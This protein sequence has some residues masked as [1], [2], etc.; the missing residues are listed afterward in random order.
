MNL[1]LEHDRRFLTWLKEVQSSIITTSYKTNYIFCI[2]LAELTELNQEVLKPPREQLSLWQTQSARCMGVGRTPP[3]KE[4][5]F[6]SI[7]VGNLNMLTKYSYF[8]DRIDEG[9]DPEKNILFRRKPF[10][11]L[12]VPRKIHVTSDIDIH[13]IAISNGTPHFV[14]AVFSCVC[15]PSETDSFKVYWKP[16]WIS[17]IAAE[18]RTHLNGLCTVPGPDGSGP[19]PKYVTAVARTDT[20]GGWRDHKR[21]GGVIFDIVNNLLVSENLSMPHSPRW[22]NCRLWVLNS[23]KGQFGYIDFDKPINDNFVPLCFI[24][25]FLRG[26]DFI[27]GYAVIGSSEDRH[28]KTFQGLELGEILEEKKIKA[29]CAIHIVDLKT[30]DIVHEI[31]FGTQELYDVTILPHVVRPIID[32]LQNSSI[33]Q[34]LSVE[35]M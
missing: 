35:L 6:D 32:D 25:G 8:G 5:S 2:G 27:K 17:K 29:K 4:N 9:K 24:P 19:I 33:S 18:D 15:V 34:R 3:S 20:R 14:S 31:S 23:G 22:Y 26:L 21:D 7:W 28:E 11:A 1:Q 16:P 13:D 30:Y 10:D 12:Y